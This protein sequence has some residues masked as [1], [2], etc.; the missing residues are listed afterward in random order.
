MTRLARQDSMDTIRS[1][2]M[3]GALALA[4]CT[5]DS[6]AQLGPARSTGLPFEVNTGELETPNSL[7]EGFTTRNPMAPDTGVVGVTHLPP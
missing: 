7:P 2:V 1:L 6:P 5:G 3:L 4:S